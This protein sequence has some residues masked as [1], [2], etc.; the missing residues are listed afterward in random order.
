MFFPDRIKN[1]SPTDKV[2][3]I[4]T[5]ASPYPRSDVFLDK[6]FDEHEAYKQCGEQEHV[7]YVKPIY[8]YDGK[9]FPFQENEFDYII[10]SHVLE[11]VSSEHIHHFISELQRVAKKGY[12]ETPRVFYEYLFN[13]SVHEWMLNYRNQEL[14]LMSKKEFDFSNINDAYYIMFQHGFVKTQ[15]SLIADFIDFF[16]V[17]IRMGKSHSI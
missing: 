17:R 7:Q 8:Y 4:G 6:S 3:E 16:Y 14:V 2:L 1:I 10:C 11:H 5:G 15:N 12:I 13:F 9:T